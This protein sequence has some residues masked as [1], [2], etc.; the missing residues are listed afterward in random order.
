[1]ANH[2][3]AKKRARQNIARNIRNVSQL[4]S[5]KSVVKKVRDAITKKDKA[6]AQK[7]LPE[8]QGLLNK[9]AQTGVIK[10]ETASRRVSRLAG[11][12]A[13]LT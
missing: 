9:L 7:L 2:P 13:H 4:S 11:Q 10:K 12:V 8:A 1:V 5:V 6:T 3:S